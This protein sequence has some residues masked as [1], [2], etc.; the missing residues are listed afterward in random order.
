[1]ESFSVQTPN[2]GMRTPGG[3]LTRVTS[4]QSHPG[5][6]T[7]AGSSWPAWEVAGRESNWDPA[8]LCRGRTAGEERKGMP[9]PFDRLWVQMN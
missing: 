8:A 4:F 6:R 1:M 3:A 5:V 7:G 9:G 2:L